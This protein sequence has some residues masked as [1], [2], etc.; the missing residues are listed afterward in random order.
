MSMACTGWSGLQVWDC[1]IVR[2]GLSTAHFM[3]CMHVR[4]VEQQWAL[5]QTCR[6]ERPPVSKHSEQC[7]TP[8][9][10]YQHKSLA[11]CLPVLTAPCC[12]PVPRQSS[13]VVWHLSCA[14]GACKPCYWTLMPTPCGTQSLAHS[15][16]HSRLQA[17]TGAWL[18]SLRP[19]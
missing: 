1:W 7:A 16:Q 5:G 18:R 19:H 4:P 10:P 15:A 6:V 13:Q 3:R 14:L 12:V 17:R 2:H 11:C 8:R 9:P